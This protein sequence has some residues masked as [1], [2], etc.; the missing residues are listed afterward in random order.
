ML[1]QKFLIDF[2][3]K[4]GIYLLTALT[5]IVVARLAGPEVVGIIAYA[6]AYVSVFSFITGLFGSAHIKLVSE[7]EDEAD[8]L[9]TYRWLWG[10][11]IVVFTLVVL[12]FYGIQKVL[13]GYNFESKKVE[14]V[15]LITLGAIIFG[16]I[17]PFSQTVFIARTEQAKS[18]IPDFLKAIIYNV[19]RIIVVVMGM[20][21]IALASVNFISA[22]LLLPLVMYL[23]QGKKFGKFRRSLVK[24]FF[25]I[26]IPLFVMVITGSLIMYSDK[27]ILGYYGN[28]SEI[29]FYGAAFSIGGML[30]LFGNT[31][32]TVFFP[33]FSSYFAKNEINQVK[34]KAYQFEHFIFIFVLPIIISLSLFAHPVLITLLGSRYEPSV[35]IFSLLV[36][37]SFFIIWSM[38]YGNV[39]AGLGLFWLGSVLHFVKFLLFLVTLFIFIHPRLLNMGGMALAITQVVINLFM[40][41][42]FYY[43]T[44]KKINVQ[45]VKEQIKY[46]LFWIVIYGLSYYVL[47]PVISTFSIYLQSFVV[48]PV[49]LVAIYLIEHFLGLLKIADLKMLWQLLNPKTSLQYVKE[50]FKDHSHNEP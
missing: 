24:K 41:L 12:G 42:A 50:E 20:G 48:V 32:G 37:S 2:G 38:P 34:R 8:C 33:L 22:L 40:F 44:W 29:G 7:G 30:I 46:I 35:P 25:S 18:N 17:Y 14:L 3:A 36:F 23:L 6:T 21:A 4:F 49:F 9:A 1:K 31:A 26:S 45:F 11:S 15:V 43:I 13:M 28:T 47:L 5:G 39:L 16:N 10:I 19:L 27:L